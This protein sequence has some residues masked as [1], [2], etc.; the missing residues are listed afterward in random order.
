MHVKIETKLSASGKYINIGEDRTK[1]STTSNLY[2]E[3]EDKAF[4]DAWKMSISKEQASKIGH[5]LL[6]YAGEEPFN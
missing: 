2:I 3:M 1:D 4:G 6:K 5:A